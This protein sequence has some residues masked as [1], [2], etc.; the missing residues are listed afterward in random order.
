MILGLC[1]CFSI[2]NFALFT[3]FGFVCPL[4]GL[5]YLPLLHFVKISPCLC[6]T[7][8]QVAKQWQELLEEEQ[9][10]LQE[11]TARRSLVRDNR[12]ASAL[13]RL[14]EGVVDKQTPRYTSF[15]P[16]RL[17]TDMVR[18]RKSVHVSSFFLLLFFCCQ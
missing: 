8:L 2:A 5:H 3:G 18:K 15:L 17:Y 6:S 12:V 10:F 14:R 1:K 4:S 7:L 9:Q 16:D 11:E 13:D